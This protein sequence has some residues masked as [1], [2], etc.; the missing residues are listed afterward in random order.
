MELMRDSIIEEKDGT[1]EGAA[2]E[3]LG[4]GGGGGG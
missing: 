3:L 2:A 4:G 1:F